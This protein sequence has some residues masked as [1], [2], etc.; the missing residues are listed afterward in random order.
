M[1]VLHLHRW[2][3]N[4]TAL[5]TGFVS[6][7]GENENEDFHD[8]D[9]IKIWSDPKYRTKHSELLGLMKN[10]KFEICFELDIGH[11]LAPQLLPVD[12][13]DYEWNSNDN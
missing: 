3:Q 10:P 8:D 7:E 11:Y 2:R 13:V 6:V 5:G 9:L 4:F 1:K 12:E